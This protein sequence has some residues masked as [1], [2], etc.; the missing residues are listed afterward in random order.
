MDG[1]N[2]FKSPKKRGP[3]LQYFSRNSETP[4][5]KSSQYFCRK[6]AAERNENQNIAQ[7]P[8]AAS[9]QQQH[10]GKWRKRTT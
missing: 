3:Y 8:L 5:P 10:N 2:A 4:V 6:K 1:K 7:P 9:L